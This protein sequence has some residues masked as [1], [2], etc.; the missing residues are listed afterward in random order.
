MTFLSSLR[1]I[2]AS[3][4]ALVNLLT[5]LAGWLKVNFGDDPARAIEEHAAAIKLVKE[6]KTPDEKAR[7]AAALSALIRK[8]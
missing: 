8:L 2:V 4:P 6:A 7:A 3:V 1:I 5:E